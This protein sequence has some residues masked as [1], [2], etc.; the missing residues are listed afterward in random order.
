MEYCREKNNLNDFKSY[1][2][3]VQYLARWYIPFLYNYIVHFLS[4]VCALLIRGANNF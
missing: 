4:I 1:C 3:K 2:N